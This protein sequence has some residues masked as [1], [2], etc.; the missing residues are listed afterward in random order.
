LA[1]VEPGQ[2]RRKGE[3]ADNGQMEDT[4]M[5]RYKEN[6]TEGSAAQG[7]E[8]RD[9]RDWES[10]SRDRQQGGYGNSNR[11]QNEQPS[12]DRNEAGRSRQWGD[13]RG[14]DQ[15]RYGSGFGDDQYGSSRGYGQQ[16]RFDREQSDMRYGQG[17]GQSGQSGYGGGRYGES[18]QGFFGQSGRSGYGPYMG[19]G[20]DRQMGGYGASD[21]GWDSSDW[22]RGNRGHDRGFLERAGDEVSSWF[23][24]DEAQR[25]READHRGKGPRGYTRSDDRI[26]E[27]VSDKLG[28]DPMVDASDIDVAVENGE[29]TL[30]GEVTSRQAKR[31][32]EDCVDRVAGVRH[33]QNNLRVK[34]SGLSGETGHG[35]SSQS[36]SSGRTVTPTPK[37]N[38]I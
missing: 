19:Q 28:D 36:E 5:S 27:D 33:V 37:G 15:G 11:Q 18:G 23:G 7:G 38:A 22:N 30:S 2:A 34:T 16:D 10:G 26:R 8:R 31:Q 21:R 17:Y 20:G 35:M 3:A 14:S 6:D 1:V 29:V 12:W 25:R 13:N 4:R 24:D 32:A 9:F